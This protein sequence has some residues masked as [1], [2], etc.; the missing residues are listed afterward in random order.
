MQ[1]HTVYKRKT[2]RFLIHIRTELAALN[3]LCSD[4]MQLNQ[5]Y[6]KYRVVIQLDNL[7]YSR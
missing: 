6:I 7:L 5:Q 1:V 2:R 3:L 4:V